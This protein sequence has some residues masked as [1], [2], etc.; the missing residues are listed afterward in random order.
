MKRAAERLG[1]LL[2]L[3]GAW[4]C[5]LPGWGVMAAEGC[6]RWQRP[7]AA[8]QSLR[9][10]GRVSDAGGASVVGAEVV[11]TLGGGVSV[12]EVTDAGGR[13]S[14][15][16]GEARRGL[17]VVTARGFAR[18][19]REWSFEERGNGAPLLEIVLVPPSLS[20]QV[21]VTAARTETRL[22][23]TPASVVVLSAEELAA[24]PAVTLD[25]AL[26][27]VPGFQ[28]FRRAGS[29]TANPTTQGVS[30]RGTGASGA[31][32]ALVLVD[33]LP[34]NDPFGGWVYW[35]RVP[36]ES[37]SR[38][39]VLRGGSSHLYGSGALGGVVQILTRRPATD[40]LSFELSYG[41]QQTPDVSLFAGKRKGDWAVALASE[42]FSTQG[43]VTIDERE[44]GAVDVPAGSRRATVDLSVERLLGERGRLF[45][46]LSYFAETRENG[47]PLQ[48]NGTRTRTLALGADFSPDGLG[49]FALRAYAS[50]QAYDQS[51]SAIASER[52]SEQLTRV[53]RVPSQV[54]GVSAQWSRVVARAHTIVA[55][56]DAREVRG[57]SD[58]VVY[59]QG[60]QSSL[61]GAGG[62]ERSLGAFAEAI[63]RLTKG[64]LVTG[65]VRFDRWREYRA[66]TLT[67]TLRPP[68]STTLRRF[69][70]RDET[71]FSPHLS[72][73]YRPNDRLSF[74]A[75]FSRA[76]RAPTLN[77]LYRSF[78][79][80]DVLTLANENLRAERLTGG[81]AGVNLNLR[82]RRMEL[83]TTLFW[84][85][86]TRPIANVTLGTTPALITRRRENL[87]RTRSRGLELEMETR[88]GQRVR[89][90]AGYLF[91]DARVRRFPANT[92]L[93]N[94]LL[95]Q[96]ARH[97]LTL[98]MRYTNPA[99]ASFSLQARAS[100]SQFDDDQNRFP[101]GRYLTLDALVSRPL[102]RHLA[103]FAAA[104]NLLNQRSQTARTPVTALSPPL[105]FRFGL[106]L[107]Y[108]TP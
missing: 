94:L 29:R 78:R 102:G 20:E 30:L 16:V 79:V 26:R 106:R 18:F 42:L 47:T 70:E 19:E 65:G 58:E 54:A 31:S 34:L 85:E 105:L 77:E 104:E 73:L 101:L 40:A 48:T 81:E 46:R 68:F 64:M 36:R 72:A 6:G 62:R 9:V 76:F 38:V 5:L 108:G 49:A 2:V 80:G 10:E 55:G 28:L 96:V 11:L 82:D 92:T 4:G 33:G 97:Q 66:Q 61:V 51:F 69:P 56:V 74:S 52:N 75:S 87:G 22:G 53:Q 12:R 67:R 99:I 14:L 37:I 63:L 8:A 59:A 41:N 60:A 88:L 15:S 27:Q 39:E 45:S 21:T 103:L 32:R 24:T 43:Y 50:A 93:E 91:A 71:A 98:Q 95:P 84:A 7:A 1:L 23:E 83:R 89:L 13:F 3:A 86:L 44:R 25:D 100:G 17:L 107:S 90:V 35:G 57:A